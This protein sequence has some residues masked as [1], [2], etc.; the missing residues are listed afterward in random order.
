MAVFEN[1]TGAYVSVREDRK[2]RRLAFAG[3]HQLNGDRSLVY[4]R[5]VEQST[6]APQCILAAQ[7]GRT[8]LRAKM[9]VIKL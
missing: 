4:R 7:Q 5:R 6:I 9:A 2:R 3:Q 8:G 1:R